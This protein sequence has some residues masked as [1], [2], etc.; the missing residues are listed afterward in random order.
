MNKKK[1]IP[2]AVLKVLEPFNQKSNRLY[3]RVLPTR[4][5]LVGYIDSE[6]QSDFMFQIVS[7]ENTTGTYRLK[8]RVK[9]QSDTSIDVGV[10]TIGMN[11]VEDYFTS[12]VQR[13]SGYDKH[14]GPFITDPFVEQY[15]KEFF[16]QFEILD[17]DADYASYDFQTQ[18]RIDT[19]LEQVH[20]VVEENR[21]NSNAPLVDEVINEIADLRNT[22]TG[23]TKKVV[24]EKISKIMAKVRKGGFAMAKEA[25]KIF[26]KEIVGTVAKH[27]MGSESV[28]EIVNKIF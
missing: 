14:K 28:V 15:Q 3:K 8:I 24:F 23:L 2:L 25:M 5:F 13:L 20:N 27:I 21:T 12:W 4:E 7:F 6:P 19:F 1:D 16:S 26:A 22:Q 9:P 17:D 10:L 18:H 11:K